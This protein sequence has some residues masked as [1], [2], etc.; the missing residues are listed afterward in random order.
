MGV[1]CVGHG[2]LVSP[3]VYHVRLTHLQA[4]KTIQL[5][6]RG[7]E[8]A[9]IA[10]FFTEVFFGQ[11]EISNDFTELMTQP[12]IES[13]LESWAISSSGIGADDFHM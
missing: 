13:I 1:S 11:D 5:Y 12:Q 3:D 2:T 10:S 9:S 4:A 7:S 8:D 6:S